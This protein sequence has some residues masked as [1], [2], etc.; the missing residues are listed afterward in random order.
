MCQGQNDRE[1]RRG[2]INKIILWNECNVLFQ[3]IDNT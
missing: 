1:Q 3:R 2:V